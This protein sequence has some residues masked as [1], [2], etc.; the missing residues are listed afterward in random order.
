M[1][2]ALYRR[3]RSGDMFLIAPFSSNGTIIVAAI[4]TN[5]H[6]GDGISETI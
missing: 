1:A 3:P 5:A 2:L 6:K 4:I